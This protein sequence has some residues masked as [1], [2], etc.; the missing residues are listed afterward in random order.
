MHSLI[1]QLIERP[2]EKVIV[3]L[4]N[5]EG[6]L[7]DELLSV[8]ATK[9]ENGVGA[10]TNLRGLIELTNQ[11]AKDCY[12]CGIRKGND[13]IERYTLEDEEVMEAAQFAYDHGFGYVVIQGGELS[14]PRFVRRVDKLVLGIKAIGKQKMGI[15][16]SLGEQKEETYRRWREFGVN[17]YLLRIEASERELYEQIHPVDANHDFD[18]R[19]ES[20]MRLK[21]SGIL[22]GTGV[23]IGLPGQTI[24]HLA[25]DLL[26]MKNL[27]IDMC[28][29]GPYLEQHNTPLYARRGELWDRQKRFDISLK[30]IATLRILMPH[31]NIAA[32]T[33]METI[34]PEGRR[35]AIRAGGNVVMPNITPA[36]YKKSY[37]LYDNK[38]GYNDRATIAFEKMKAEVE[39]AGSYF[40]LFTQEEGV[41]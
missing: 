9:R 15:T 35:M 22:T 5:A 7:K 2:T 32:A 26:F 34:V 41:E 16:L 23:M 40:R 19:K 20:L 27:P 24:N 6:A 33:A 21:R 36:Q 37:S 31:I 8:A 1:A 17:R 3:E 39:D 13:E 11:C 25:K 28:G 4:L 10:H 29:M 38:A 14:S 30:M 18:V 12:Y